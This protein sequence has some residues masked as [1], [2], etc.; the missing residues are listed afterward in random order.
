[1][2]ALVNG[3]RLWYESRGSGEPLV[4]LH[5]GVA[6]SRMWDAQVMGLEG[7]FRVIRF[8]A[9]GFGRSDLPAGPYAMREDLRALLDHLE[10][11]SAH[12][13][14]CSMGGA[15]ALDFAL[16]NPIRARS[17]CLVS[18][19]VG[20][21]RFGEEDQSVFAE[22][23][24]AEELGDLGALNRA[25]V[26]V[27]LDGPGRPSG[28]V[29]GRVRELVLKMNHAALRRPW[30]IAQ[31]QPMIPPAAGRLSELALPVLAVVGEHDVPAVLAAARMIASEVPGAR[32]EVVPDAAHL[33]SLEHPARFNRLLTDFVTAAHP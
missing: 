5:A 10:I 26:R 28:S 14:G 9:R 4:L 17:L 31:N 13:A 11:E 27:W 33:L 12:L 25:E 20:G 15:V 23:Q 16:E 7:A 1:M 29:G 2:E 19:G 21:S 32:L 22:V 30:D 24:A 6:D 3:A 8:D 18:A